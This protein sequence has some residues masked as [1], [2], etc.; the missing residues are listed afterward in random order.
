[1]TKKDF[2]N[3]ENI[4]R[5]KSAE[6]DW[7]NHHS[8]GDRFPEEAKGIAET[9]VK[10]A[11]AAGDGALERSDKNLSDKNDTGLFNND[12]NDAQERGQIDPPY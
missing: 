3:N 4:D 12:R 10:N 5:N 6:Q 11:H 9:E 2:T 1:M 8:T 7:E